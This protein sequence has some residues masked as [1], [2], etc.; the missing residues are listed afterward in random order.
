MLSNCIPTASEDRNNKERGDVFNGGPHWKWNHLHCW[1]SFHRHISDT[2]FN[3]SYIRVR[4]HVHVYLKF[5]LRYTKKSKACLTQN[6]R[7]IW[8]ATRVNRTYNRTNHGL[9]RLTLGPFVCIRESRVWFLKL[10]K[11]GTDLA[12]VQDRER[13][14]E[15][16]QDRI[17]NCTWHPHHEWV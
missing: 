5:E 11:I 16:V 3:C 12:I 4:Q 7:L 1:I 6:T 10:K 2:P 9:I 13:P 14:C 17:Y 15:T 8:L